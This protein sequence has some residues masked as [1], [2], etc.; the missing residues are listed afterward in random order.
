MPNKFEVS[1][2]ESLGVTLMGAGMT[3][4]ALGLTME[5][6]KPTTVQPSVTNAPTT[7]T[8]GA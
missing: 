6:A 5:A 2:V 7:P 3:I 8:M 4:A 1:G